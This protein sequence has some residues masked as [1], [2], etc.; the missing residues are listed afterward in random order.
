MAKAVTVVVNQD[1][2]EAVI[3]ELASCLRSNDSFSGQLRDFADCLEKEQRVQGINW[4]PQ[5][6][7]ILVCHFVLGFRQPEMVKTRPVM[8]ISPKVAPWTKLCVVVPISSKTPEPV[9]GHHYKLPN[10]LIPGDKY[11]EAWIKGDTVMAVGCHRLDRI[12]AGFRTYVS[13]IAPAEVLKEVRRCVLHATG[14]HSLTI[15]W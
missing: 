5:S 13:P 14:M 3:Q 12:K 11:E 7:Q 4:Q 15:H 1:A 2:D 8:V 9:L 6:G 10:S